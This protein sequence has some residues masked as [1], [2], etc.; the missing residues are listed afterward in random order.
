MATRP[1]AVLASACLLGVLLAAAASGDHAEAGTCP[2]ANPNPVW[3]TIPEWVRPVDQLPNPTRAPYPSYAGYVF[4]VAIDTVSPIAKASGARIFVSQAV[5]SS[6]V[7]QIP[8]GNF[9]SATSTPDVIINQTWTSPD[10][11]GFTLLAVDDATGTVYACTD[12]AIYSLLPNGTTQSVL[13]LTT[14]H[15]LYIAATGL[16][17]DA[18]ADTTPAA[19]TVDANGKL[20]I[21]I[22]SFNSLPVPVAAP[23]ISVYD[24]ATGIL[25]PLSGS[26]YFYPQAYAQAG[27][28]WRVIPIRIFFRHGF[29]YLVDDEQDEFYRTQNPYSFFTAATDLDANP[30][31]TQTATLNYN[32]VAMVAVDRNT[33]THYIVSNESVGER[34]LRRVGVATGAHSGLL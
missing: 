28:G 6:V 30:F 1:L 3:K 15:S 11:G 31:V 17:D 27:S 32:N 2:N 25:V 9:L 19:L 29:F 23:L 8:G 26:R 22:R 16:P 33:G 10:N 14:F 5:G 7:V 18:F 34:G 12:A 24:P 20:F 4:T 13:P 21:A